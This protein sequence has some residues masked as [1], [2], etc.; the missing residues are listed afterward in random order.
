M[1]F[2]PLFQFRSNFESFQITDYLSIE[3]IEDYEKLISF[4]DNDFFSE[5][6][7][8]RVY[9]CTYYLKITDSYI[10]FSDS[11]N[12]AIINNTF[13][14]ACWIQKS[15]KLRSEFIF[16]LELHPERS[17]LATPYCIRI[18]HRK[19]RNKN[20]QSQSRIE[21][22]DLLLIKNYFNKLIIIYENQYRLRFASTFTFFG[23]MS[24][25]W[26]EAYIAFT[27]AFETLLTHKSN[28]GIKKKIALACACI[29]EKKHLERNSIFSE[30]CELYKFRSDFIHGKMQNNLDDYGHQYLFRFTAVQLR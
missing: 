8:K 16:G 19:K 25:T 11:N 5:A 24:M 20:E 14:I 18:L 29:L 6:E 23:M 15:F 10:R 4:M 3:K 1:Y 27:T 13:L 26:I 28:Y 9:Q 17:D 30:F 7:R 12:I 21:Q 2:I 22:E